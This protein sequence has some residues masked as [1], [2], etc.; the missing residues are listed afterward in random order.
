MSLEDLG[1]SVGLQKLDVDFAAVEN[2]DL[3][4]YCKRDVEIMVEA[5]RRWLDFVDRY[6]L[7]D[8]RY[9]VAGQAW[10]AYRHRFLPCDIGIHSDPRA[11]E[12]ERAAYRGGRCEP[13]FVGKLPPG[14]YYKL[15]ANGLYAAMMRWY[16]YPRKLVKV[17]RSIR[18]YYLAHLL[19][20]NLA[21]AEVVLSTTTP[22][23]PLRV[24]GRN[25]YPTG[26]FLTTLTTAELEIALF[27]DEVRAIG[28]VALYEP[29]DLFS[30][31]IDFFTPLRQQ[32]K[33]DGD[34]ARSK[35]CKRLRNSLPGKF[36]QRGYTQEK[37]GDAPLDKVG[38]RLWLDPETGREAVDLI[39]GGSII[40]QTREDEA[41]DSFPAIPAHLAAYGRLYMWSLIEQAGRRNVYYMD[42]DSLLVNQAGMDNLTAVVDPL[43]LGYL[44]LEGTASEV[45]VS[46]PKDYTFGDRTVRKG[47]RA[48]ALEVEDGVFDQ[49]HFTHLSYA[50]RAHNLEGVT[51]YKARKKLERG[52]VA[53]ELTPSGWVTPPH[54]TL[55]PRKLLAIVGAEVDS[56]L[57]TWEF[58]VKWASGL[59]C[60]QSVSNRL[61]LGLRWA[62]KPPWTVQR[63]TSQVEPPEAF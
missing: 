50:F 5:W 24:K 14:P 40:R 52:R 18:P 20:T 36:G 51:V 41:F 23:Y 17:M 56:N 42:T 12:L 9:T 21:I 62:E 29:A 43:K 34:H 61:A 22:R 11:I 16:P 46:A 3:R 30:G 26:T 25:A 58:D 4:V 48:N 7:G 13:F 45:E 39:F 28:R 10:S 60:V 19:K 6:D 63:W 8:F 32:Y 55:T 57:W 37:V 33:L 49:W 53:G 47:V 27:N 35:M 44:K 38:R 15:D 59:E 31:Y 2:E 1:R 54:L